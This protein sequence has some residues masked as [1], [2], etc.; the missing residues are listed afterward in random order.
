MS[1]RRKRLK[2][3]TVNQFEISR[4][5]TIQTVLDEMRHSPQVGRQLERQPSKRWLLSD[6]RFMLEAVKLYPFIIRYGSHEIKDDLEIVTEAS[7]RS[8]LVFRYLPERTQEPVKTIWINKIVP[9]LL[10]MT[11]REA[12]SY[13]KIEFGFEMPFN[14]EKPLIMRLKRWASPEWFAEFMKIGWSYNYGMATNQSFNI[15]YMLNSDDETYVSKQMDKE[16]EYSQ[17]VSNSRYFS[18]NE[19]VQRIL[20]DKF[21]ERLLREG[22]T[23]E[24]VGN[25]L[26]ELPVATIHYLVEKMPEELREGVY[27][28]LGNKE[29]E[30]RR[31]KITKNIVKKTLQRK[32]GYRPAANIVSYMGG[33]RTTLKKRKTNGK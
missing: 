21:I 26:V 1:K 16:L 13:L 2:T 14:I 18:A 19:R 6:R 7:K 27:Q 9:K 17:P 10:K 24:E 4:E 22:G 23:L 8:E 33:K 25:K 20:A 32:F 29:A 31:E 3:N 11:P 5:E 15:T 28:G 12:G 30:V